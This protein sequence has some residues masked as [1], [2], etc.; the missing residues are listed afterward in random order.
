MTERL[1]FNAALAGLDLTLL[2]VEEGRTAEVKRL[3]EEMLPLFLAQDFHREAAA[4]LVLFQ[5][6][7]ERE[8]VTA[9]MLTELIAYLRRVHVR[10]ADK[11]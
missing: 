5:E 7:V 11:Q 6:A 8:A 1:G 10:P 3:A 4:A 2:Y 9:P